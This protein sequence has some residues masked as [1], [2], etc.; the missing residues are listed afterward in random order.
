MQSAPRYLLISGVIKILLCVTFC[1]LFCYSL[2]AERASL[3]TSN[4]EH[5]GHGDV[6][7]V[8]TSSPRHCR[9]VDTDESGAGQNHFFVVGGLIKITCGEVWIGLKRCAYNTNACS[10]IPDFSMSL[11]I[12]T[13]IPPF[14]TSSLIFESVCFTLLNRYVRK[15][16]SFITA[17]SKEVV[18]FAQSRRL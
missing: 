2:S 4:H 8:L 9:F 3:S 10:Q 17:A 6:I 15:V 12:Q 11:L 5:I 18:R 7:Q 1:D 16:G 13:E 14:Y